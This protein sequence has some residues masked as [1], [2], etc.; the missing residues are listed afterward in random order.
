MRV[1]E[2]SSSMKERGDLWNCNSARVSVEPIRAVGQVETLSTVHDWVEFVPNSL[3]EMETILNSVLWG[4]QS[5]QYLGNME[6]A[7]LTPTRTRL[8]TTT[9]SLLWMESV[10]SS[11]Q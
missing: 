1:L 3:E 9:P 5:N 6:R 7:N 8:R 4:L 10:L 2:E 11:A